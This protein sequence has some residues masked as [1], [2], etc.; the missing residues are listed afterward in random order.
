MKKTL[1]IFL[2]FMVQMTWAQKYKTDT[3]ISY[4][5]KTDEYSTERLKLDIYYPEGTKDCPVVVWFHGGG[6]VQGENNCL[7][8]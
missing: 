7:G 4:T 2:A 1:I 8:N 3:D 6:L 5:S